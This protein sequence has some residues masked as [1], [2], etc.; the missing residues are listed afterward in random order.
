MDG[1]TRAPELHVRLLGHFSLEY[2]GQAVTSLE[3][4]RLH[5][6]LAALLLRHGAPVSRQHLAFSF[7]PDSTE[8]Q[9]RTNLRHLLHKLRGAWPAADRCL[10]VESRTLAWQPEIP[11]T[12]DVAAFADALA[13]AEQAIQR[14][15]WTV[16][17]EAL[18]KAAETYRGDLLPECHDAWI[19]AERGRL[20]Q[21]HL[22]ALERLA[23]LLEDGRDYA[24]ALDYARRL[25]RLEPLRESGYEALMRLHALHGDRASALRVYTECVA[26]LR[27]EL[28]ITPGPRVQVLFQRLMTMQAPVAEAASA[29]YA[30]PSDTLPLIGRR[31]AW[32]QL[33]RAWGRAADGQAQLLVV[34]GEAG[35]GKSRLVAELLQWVERQGGSVAST[36]SYAAEGRL[37]FAPVADWL[38]TET[39]R[40]ALPRLSPVWLSEVSRLLPELRVQHPDLP[41]PQPVRESW[42]RLRMF[43]AFSRA[44]LGGGGPL[45]LL[46]DDLQWTDSETLAWLRY[47]L[48]FA[49][50][51]R[52]LVAATV[53]AEE[54]DAEPALSTL[55]AELRGEGL[56]TEVA[57]GPLDES[58]TAGLA[59]QLTGRPLEGAE[60]AR[61][62]GETAG[63][64]LFV[65]ET[66]RAGLLQEPAGSL[67]PKIQAVIAS[68][69]ARLSPEARALA[70]LAATVGHPFTLDLLTEASGD[71]EGALGG[72]LEELWRRRLIRAYGGGV[73]DFSHDK[74]REVAYAEI[75]PVRRQVLH[76][77]VARALEALHADDLDV[78]SGRIAAHYEEA[79]QLATAIPYYRRAG[80]RAK[81]LHANHEAISLFRKALALLDG[82]PQT[83]PRSHEAL[84]LRTAL[85]TCL[86]ASQGYGAPEVRYL[87]EGALSLCEQL[88]RPRAAPILRGLAIANLVT[89][90]LRRAST[91]GEEILDQGRQTRDPLLLAEGHYVLG[92]STFWMGRFGP[93]RRHLD[94]TVRCYEPQQHREHVTLFAQDP[95]VAC[96]CRLGRALWY[97]GHPD[98]AGRK[99]EDGRALARVLGH[100]FSRGYAEATAAQFYLEV[101][102]LR[103]AGECVETLLPLA[104]EQGFALYAAMGSVWLGV[105]M[106]EQGMVEAGIA[107]V[108]QGIETYAATGARI[109]LPQF[110]GLLART[111]L[112]SKRTEEGMSALAEGKRVMERTDERFYEAELLRLE[113]E[114]LLAG[115][116][117]AESGTKCFLAA[118]AVARRQEA[119]SLEL[120]VAASLGRLWHRRGEA[121][122]AVRMLRDVY[123]WF[124]E[125]FD[126]P[127]LQEARHLLDAWASA[128]H[129]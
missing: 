8:K 111:Y 97:L 84:A 34:V 20:R 33:E 53:R 119:R 75:G 51:A 112:K 25:Q 74:Q 71:E 62:H 113:G 32:M 19:E 104:S 27:R 1:S 116:E 120:A 124:T 96:L 90:D 55:L 83:P 115:D 15:S 105:L 52:L 127:A 123:T 63:N 73:Y 36:R 58:E 72:A 10:R 40:A 77:Q 24:G 70:A 103:R 11:F 126:T 56:L 43:D 106:A 92:A 4:P 98:Q 65:V 22:Q 12:L 87:Y 129:T 102:D 108:R 114:L 21:E 89:G 95:K 100:P 101:G 93:S 30:D 37:T 31:D 78:V 91:L 45:L 6:L 50:E 41:E 122:A 86:V 125:G 2:A 17:Q 121:G 67:P 9:A 42:Q 66:V 13:T 81:G 5:A 35:I 88:G 60:A 57:L 14:A 99:V 82:Q 48:R 16:A 23:R 3:S 39:L 59:A 76:R 7:W 28:E 49:P 38:R 79:G 18:R 109:V 54:A 117:D 128:E 85:G 46:L 80:E 44:V 107:R 61:L 47:L 26:I 94:Q 64:P 68:R 29:T 110:Y 118:L 69:L